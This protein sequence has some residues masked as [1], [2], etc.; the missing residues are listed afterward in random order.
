[1]ADL[2]ST[3]GMRFYIGPAM[4]TQAD[5]FVLADFETSPAKSWTEVDMWMNAGTVGDTAQVITTPVINRGRDLKQKGTRNAGQMQLVFGLKA[6]DAGQTALR[7]A[8]AT[9]NNYA[10]KIEF[11]DKAATS[12]ATNSLR[13]FVGLVMSA[14]EQFDEANNVMRLNVSLEV[15]SNIVP[16]AAA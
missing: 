11:N 15:N 12:G 14:A 4:D 2:Y 13:Y 8:E 3:A 16:K 9:P 1:M 5:D 7:A 6:S 10:F